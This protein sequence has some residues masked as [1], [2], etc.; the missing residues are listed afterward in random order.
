MPLLD[1]SDN[2]DELNGNIVANESDLTGDSSMDTASPRNSS[3]EPM[4]GDDQAS[5]QVVQSSGTR[6]AT[7]R[8]TLVFREIHTENLPGNVPSTCEMIFEDPD[9]LHQ[10]EV[11]V[12]PREGYW[13][14]GRFLFQ[15]VVPDGYNFEV[16]LSLVGTKF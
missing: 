4:S 12:S 2:E 7:V 3:P 14:G 9:E 6:R 10:F 11:A 13:R 5:A 1:L 15:I 8:D 16:S